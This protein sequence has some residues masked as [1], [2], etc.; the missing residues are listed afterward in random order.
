M[1]L[2]DLELDDPPLEPSDE[3]QPAPLVRRKGRS[4]RSRFNP[5]YQ[6]QQPGAWKAAQEERVQA[7]PPWMLDRSKLPLKPPGKR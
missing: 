4:G 7:R 6:V 1:K 5:A 3:P 2:S